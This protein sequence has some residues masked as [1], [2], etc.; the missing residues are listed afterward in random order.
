MNK[1]AQAPACTVLIAAP[2][3]LP[4]LKTRSFE[5]ESELLSF[6]DAEALRAL[7]V[8]SR[9]RPRLIALERTFAA[10]PRGAALINRIKADPTLGNSEIRVVSSDAQE[11]T[12]IPAPAPAV[13]SAGPTPALLDKRGTRRAPRFKVASHVDIA[14]DGNNAKLVDLSI[15]G[16]QVVSATVLKPNQKVRLTLSDDQATIRI[17]AIVAW[18][19]FEIPP[20][21]GPRYRAGV[22]FLDGDAAA[23]DAFRTR[24]QV[25]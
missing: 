6:S 16:A 1:A 19:S 10:T 11:P 20:K 2:D 9:R 7:E 12:T 23:I 22:D 15:V 24:H 14:V 21:I 25:S 4:A 5:G 17:A 13:P 18:A 8:I 3:L